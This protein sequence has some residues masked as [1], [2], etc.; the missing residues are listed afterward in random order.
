M[1]RYAKHFVLSLVLSLTF[2]SLSSAAFAAP[3]YKWSFACPWSRPVSEKGY[4][5]FCDKVSEYTNGDIEIKLYMGGLLGTHDESFHGVRDGSIEISA[6]SPYVNLIPGGMLNWMPWTIGSFDEARIAYAYPDGIIYKLMDVAW[7]EVNCKLLFS[8]SQGAYGLANNVRPLRNPS[9]LKN[10]KMRVSSSTA[11]VRCLENM[12]A[13]TGMLME[14]LPW[15]EIYTALSRGVVDGC[16]TMLPSLV[17][18]RQCEVLKHY[19][20]NLL[21]WDANNVVIN[22]D[23]WNELKPEYQKAILKAGAEAEQ[24]LNDLHEA[25]E[26]EYRKKLEAMSGFTITKISDEERE[27]WREKA[28]MPAIWKELCDPWLEKHWPGQ[29]KSKEI[30]NELNE[31][32]RRCIEQKAAKKSS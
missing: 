29:N 4:K 27:V 16:W 13:G 15:S 32:H 20:H 22:M 30:L 9:D 25:K 17:D 1:K 6:L 2:M 14:N 12:G 18:E 3:K 24:Y 23:L 11:A 31:I 26:D 5:V 19:T 7:G 21:V 10:L 8:C 28:N